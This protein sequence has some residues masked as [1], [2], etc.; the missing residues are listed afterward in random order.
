MT[1]GWEIVAIVADVAAISP[2]PDGRGVLARRRRKRD[3]TRAWKNVL[4]RDPCSHCGGSGGTVDHID[5]VARGGRNAAPNFSGMC[6][7]CNL[8]KADVPLLYFVLRSLIGLPAVYG[9]RINRSEYP[10][11]PAMEPWWT[12]RSD[13]P[14]GP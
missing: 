3:R 10:M 2:A 13:D 6:Q 12:G 4:R 8:A 9:R 7:A 5:P 1:H 11:T 14:A